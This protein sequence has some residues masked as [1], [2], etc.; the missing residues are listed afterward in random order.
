MSNQ[1]Q[2]KTYKK[3][4]VDQYKIKSKVVFELYKYQSMKILRRLIF[5]K[6]TFIK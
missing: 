5:I 4:I 1:E 2:N 6:K 3:K